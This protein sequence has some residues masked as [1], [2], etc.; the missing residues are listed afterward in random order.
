MKRT[1]IPLCFAALASGLW[2]KAP[3]DPVVMTVDG[4]PVRVSEF[5]Y[6]RHKND[7]QQIEEETLDQFVERIINYKLKVAAAKHEGYEQSPEFQR[8]YKKYRRELAQP[9]LTDSTT[10]YAAL[11]QAYANSLEE[12][13]IQHLMVSRDRRSAI[14][15]IRT[16]IANGADFIEM[17][18]SESSDPSLERNGGYYGWIK[19]GLYPYDF[20]NATWAT[21]IG[22]VSEVITT[23]YGYH[24]T[25]VLARRPASQGELH[26]AHILVDSEEKADSLLCLLINGADFAETAK[27]N[28]SCGSAPQ[29]GDLGWFASGAMVPEFEQAAFAL[30]DGQLSS[31]VKTRFGYHI[32]KRI[33]SRPIDKAQAM[34]KIRSAAMRDQRSQLPAQYKAEQLKKLYPTSIDAKGRD[35]L[36]T[37]VENIGFNKAADSLRNDLTPLIH[38]ADSTVTIA[39]FF[40]ANPRINPALSA[41]TQIDDLLPERVNVAVRNYESNRLGYKYP[42]FLNIDREYRDGLLLF[43]IS[44][45]EIWNKPKEDPEGLERFFEENRHKYA[46]DAEHPRW[47]GFIIYATTD[48]LIQEVSAYLDRVKPA[49]NEVGDSLKANFPKYIRIERVV[50]PEKNNQIVDYIAFGG[51]EPKWL[52]SQ[53]MRYFIPYLGHY[54]TAPEEAAD[55]RGT[56]S[57]D[58]IDVLEKEWVDRLRQTYDYKVNG[59]E[60]KKLK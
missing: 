48:S 50:L 8:E 35:K 41:T 47:K 29:G 13:E 37:A 21:P 24:L 23:P 28:S 34:D 2:A 39:D 19:S 1:L 38:V 33:E 49:P 14:D 6:L 26:A 51:P 58:W 9:Y 22:Q 5:E 54:I 56:V 57:G 44:E 15:S 53:M 27:A 10:F 11:D 36:I 16:L 25:K 52:Q 12:V 32:I 59:K 46:W 55:V 45:A 4:Q 20:E 30:A 7:G 40:A 42:E 60:L 31:P 3:K 43:A 18:K 17:A